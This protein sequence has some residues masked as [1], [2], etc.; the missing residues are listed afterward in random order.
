MKDAQR[1]SGNNDRGLGEHTPG[2]CLLLRAIFLALPYVARI[3]W[4]FLGG[5]HILNGENSTLDSLSDYLERSIV[6]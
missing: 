6:F 4:Q 3:V 5:R 2:R 1:L